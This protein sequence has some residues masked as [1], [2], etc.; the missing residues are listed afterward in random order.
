M[1]ATQH[2][3]VFLPPGAIVTSIVAHHDCHYCGSYDIHGVYFHGGDLILACV[4]CG[5]ELDAGNEPVRLMPGA[6]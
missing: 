5:P 2:P 3:P 4:K 6:D 1:T